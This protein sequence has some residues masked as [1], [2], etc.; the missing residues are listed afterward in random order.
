MAKVKHIQV[1]TL[2]T[3]LV[4]NAIYFVRNT[5]EI[6][7]TD[8]N[9]FGVRMCGNKL[10]K[11][12][13]SGNIYSQKN[14]RQYSL[15]DYQYPRNRWRFARYIADDDITLDDYRVPFI[16]VLPFDIK[17]KYIVH[18]IGMR[19]YPRPYQMIYS[20]M[21]GQLGN[22][23]NTKRHILLDTFETKGYSGSHDEN[24][25][26]KIWNENDL[27]NPVIPAGNIINVGIGIDNTKDNSNRTLFFS[28]FTIFAE[29]IL[30]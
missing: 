23:N 27:I 2:P 4:P 28:T 7:Q 5:G 10:L 9:G 14:T 22:L 29:K 1:N 3:T 16:D 8:S 13:W 18:S 30:K 21:T 15:F 6:W 25:E 26:V 24:R 12:D 11:F 20:I 19:Q 17:I